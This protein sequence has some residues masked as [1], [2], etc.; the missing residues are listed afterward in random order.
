MFS[1]TEKYRELKKFCTGRGAE[2]F[3]VADVSAL[4]ADFFLSEKIKGKI[5]KAVCLGVG[6]SDLVLSEIEGQPTK[7][8]FHHYKTAN[9]FLDQLAFSVANWIAKK[10]S[11]ALP[12][13]SSQIIDWDGQ[14]GHLSHKK[15]GYQAGIGW[16]GR[17]NLLV[18]K[19]LGAQFR[20]VTVLTDM[21][22][23][24][25]KPVRDDCGRC[26]MCLEVCPVS[27]IAQEPQGFK[28][29]TCFDKLKDFQRQNIV[30]QYICGICVKACGKKKS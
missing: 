17:N 4:K 10:G 22:L 28:H 29:Q 15:I 23:K 3:G 16:I 24:V 7:L 6:L 20:M 19:K 12:I 11:L 14:K 5:D 18:T 25:D 26:T 8:Y 27:A 9:M 13:P 2:L 1:A 30:G 21:A